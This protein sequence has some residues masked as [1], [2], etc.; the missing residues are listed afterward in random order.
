[1]RF[2]DRRYAVLARTAVHDFVEHYG[3]T[4]EMVD[5]SADQVID[6]P[7]HLERVSGRAIPLTDLRSDYELMPVPDRADAAGCD[8]V[9]F[10]E[11]SITGYP[12]EDLLLR[13]G[14]IEACREATEQFTA[15]VQ[16]I[17][18]VFGH[19]WSRGGER[20]NAASWLRDGRVL[21]RYF[22]KHLPNY[23]VFDEHRYFSAGGEPLVVEIGGVRAAVIICEDAWNPGP[24]MA[25]K[26]AG[27]GQQGHRGGGELPAQRHVELEPWS[28]RAHRQWMRALAASGQRGAALAQYETCR[29]VLAE[30][31]GVEPGAETTAL[32]ERIRGGLETAFADLLADSPLESHRFDGGVEV[33]PRGIDKGDAIRQLLAEAGGDAAVAE[34]QAVGAPDSALV[35]GSQQGDAP[36]VVVVT[37]GDEAAGEGGRTQ[38]DHSRLV[39]ADPLAAARFTAADAVVAVGVVLAAS[40]FFCRSDASVNWIS[41]RSMASSNLSSFSG[42]TSSSGR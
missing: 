38:E 33:R 19:P 36:G 15:G 14:F 12:P 9:A 25:A 28:E 11:L 20:Y 18:V 24:A 42:L 26:D 2:F 7:Q 30:E 16:G 3:I 21:G 8:L 6:L 40:I 22:K 29:Q 39:G 4:G 31:L 13:P 23:L 5:P 34:R 35:T 37:P 10:P 27:V 32:Y 17:D 1:M 41:W